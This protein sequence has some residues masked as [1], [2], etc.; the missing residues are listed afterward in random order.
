MAKQPKD[1]LTEAAKRGTKVK[2]RK[3][4][5]FT[6]CAHEY[7]SEC[8]K[9][10]VS[11]LLAALRGPDTRTGATWSTDVRNRVGVRDALERE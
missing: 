2:T 8:S 1:A 3:V 10:R 6:R 11:N 5:R 9:C 7:D 4:K